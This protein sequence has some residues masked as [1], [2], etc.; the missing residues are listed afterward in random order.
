[1]E[2]LGLVYV[3]LGSQRLAEQV[4]REALVLDPMDHL[5]WNALGQVL[6]QLGEHEA[7]ADCLASS[8][9]LESSAPVLPFSTIP[10]CFD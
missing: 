2:H 8:L 1:M 7:A 10:L 6:D 4:L 3:A 9:E 5:V